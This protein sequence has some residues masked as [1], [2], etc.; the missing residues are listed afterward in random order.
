M[1]DPGMTAGLAARLEVPGR[2]HADV[3]AEPGEIVGVIGPNGSGKST[4]LRAL[5]GL[6]PSR[7]EIEVAG[8]SW[9]QP[10]RPVRERSVGMAFQDQKLFPHL[11]A[12][13]NV[14]FGPRSRGVP[15]DRAEQVAREWL[16]R[17]G[18]GDLAGRRPG[19]LSG[20]QAQRVS[21][22]R[23]LATDPLLLLLDEPFSG[24]DIGVATTLR[25][26]LARHLASY[27]GITLLVTHDAIDALT[28]VDQVW[29]LDAGA[30][31]QVGPPAEVA[32]R[33][34]TDHVARLVGLNV[35]EEHGRFMSFSPTLVTVSL[36]EPT[37]SARHRWPGVVTS[38]APHGDAVRLLVSGERE[39]LADV[40]PAAVTEL[41]LA[42]GRRV[43][44]SVKETAVRTYRADQDRP[45]TFPHDGGARR[46]T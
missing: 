29:V 11:S 30:V 10:P 2:V 45:L 8:E 35:L 22:A 26:E 20:G 25:L 17:F 5:A 41:E 40:T 13:D 34:R 9:S 36:G 33:P 3:T 46:G 7:G 27:G 23:A 44:L 31:V 24:L 18:V 12:L 6:V 32:A 39:L 42:P 14:A 16:D 15:R 37:G 43:W 21:I 19:R 1:A 28:L 38:L 4:L